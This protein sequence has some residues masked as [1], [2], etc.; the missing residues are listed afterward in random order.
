M[1]RELLNGT[2]VI[3]FI[4]N[5]YVNSDAK[6]KVDERFLQKKGYRQSGRGL[7]EYGRGLH[8]LLFFLLMQDF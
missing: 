1:R 7:R 2:Q 4:F 5:C 8:S 3:T 6:A